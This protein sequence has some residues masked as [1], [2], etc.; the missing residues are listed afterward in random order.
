MPH[1]R[2]CIGRECHAT[3]AAATRAGWARRRR[4]SGRNI[5]TAPGRKK[6]AS[7]PRSIARRDGQ[8]PSWNGMR[9]PAIYFGHGNPMNALLRNG[10]TEAWRALG[11]AWPRPRAILAISAHWYVPVTGVTLSTAPRTI[12][13]F[14]GFP[15]ELYAVK[16]PAPGDPA[17]ARQVQK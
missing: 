7:G 3:K 16:Y 9:H 4:L 14:G 12:H 11:G 17:L 5:A 8:R 1:R 13:D 15:R 2:R 6:R 10:Y